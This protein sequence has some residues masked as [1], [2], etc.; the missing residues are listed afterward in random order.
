MTQLSKSMC[1]I[2]HALIVRKVDIYQ[3][4]GY[5]L[6]SIGKSFECKWLVNTRFFTI[7]QCLCCFF[8]Y[9]HNLIDAPISTPVNKRIVVGRFSSVVGLVCPGL[10]VTDTEYPPFLTQAKTPTRFYHRSNIAEI[11]K[12][13]LFGHQFTLQCVHV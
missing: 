13:V 7:A 6:S 1:G 8:W 5:N 9:I 2:V 11:L 3:I 10:C 4:R 12:F